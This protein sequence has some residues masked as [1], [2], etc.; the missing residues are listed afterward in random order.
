[1][2]LQVLLSCVLLFSEYL[3]SYMYIYI[4]TEICTFARHKY[5]HTHNN[6]HFP[7]YYLSGFPL[8]PPTATVAG[9]GACKLS[10]IN[11]KL[12]SR[13]LFPSTSSPFPFL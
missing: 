11:G 12:V 3:P 4:H 8:A 2:D 5:T 13:T 7:P 10:F 9:A 6:T 1:M